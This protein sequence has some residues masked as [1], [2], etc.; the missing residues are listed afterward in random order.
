MKLTSALKTMSTA[1]FVILN[2]LAQ[3]FAVLML[4]LIFTPHGPVAQDLWDAM[5][6]VA[7]LNLFLPFGKHFTKWMAVLTLTLLYSTAITIVV[8]AVK[9]LT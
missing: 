4:L 1:T 2:W 3:T 6:I 5:L 9:D 8:F 7:A